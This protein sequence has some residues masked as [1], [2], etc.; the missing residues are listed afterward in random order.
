MK[1]WWCSYRWVVAAGVANPPCGAYLCK[2]TA[3]PLCKGGR[4]ALRRSEKLQ[5]GSPNL[6]S[7]HYSSGISPTIFIVT[8]LTV[9]TRFKRSITFSL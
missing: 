6:Q 8:T 7:D 9:H 4:F 5:G 3:L 1:K 2:E